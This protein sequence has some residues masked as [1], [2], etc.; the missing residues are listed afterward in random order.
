M[1]KLSS[2]KSESVAKGRWQT[3]AKGVRLLIGLDGANGR[4]QVTDGEMTKKKNDEKC[5]IV[6]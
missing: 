3:E 2:S 5:E 6:R 4:R 1:A